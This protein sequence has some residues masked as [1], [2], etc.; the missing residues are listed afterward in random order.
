M[1]HT[2]QRR[3]PFGSAKNLFVAATAIAVATLTT[4]I[5]LTS[6][7]SSS[8]ALTGVVTSPMEGAMEGVLVS[9][10]RVD[11]TTTV[12]VVPTHK[13]ATASLGTD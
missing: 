1:V 12:T 9:A 11:S 2:S 13:G 4:V 3:G 10:K 7:E 8:A 5:S 6:A